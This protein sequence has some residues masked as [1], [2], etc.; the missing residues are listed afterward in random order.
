MTRQDRRLERLRSIP[1]DYG[2]DELVA[3]LTALGYQLSNGAG[4]RRK[5]WRADNLAPISLH[6]PHGSQPVKR[7]YI[8]YVLE[9]LIAAE[10]I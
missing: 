9:T 4:S 5:F 10:L 8:R 2:W 6:E 7:I 1:T 3:V